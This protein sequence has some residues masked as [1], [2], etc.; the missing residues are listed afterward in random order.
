[1]NKKIN[2]A[3]SALK[4]KALKEKFPEIHETKTSKAIKEAIDTFNDE[5]HSGKYPGLECYERL[6]EKKNK[7][8]SDFYKEH[9]FFMD[10]GYSFLYPE[11]IELSDFLEKYNEVFNKEKENE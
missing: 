7:I 6:Y 2:E 5:L 9:G 8:E 11:R 4:E 3:I 1:M 10:M